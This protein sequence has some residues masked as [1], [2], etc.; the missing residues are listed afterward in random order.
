MRV[1]E[2]LLIPGPVSVSNEVLTALG[3]PVPPH[4]GE[5]WVELYS[6]LTAAVAGIF[7][8]A[9]DVILLFGPGTAAVET[10]L[11]S[12]LAPGDEV[13]VGVN[14]VFGERLA[15]VARALGLRV[16]EVTPP[17]FEPVRVEDLERALDEH[18]E[19]RAFAVVHH[20]TGLGLLNPVHELCPAAHGRGLLTLVD[21]FASF[22]GV[23]IRMDE[24]GIDL[25]AGTGN[26]CLG[27]P[28]GVAPVAIGPKGWAAVND[29]RPKAAG[30]YLNLATWHRYGEM[31][32]GWHPTPTT[33]P[34][35]V[36]VA[37]KAALDEVLD[38]GL[39]AHQARI[40][41]A[42]ARVR[43]G[44]GE[45]GF[46]MVIPGP[47]AAPMT[48]AVW[49]LPGMDVTAYMTWM[50]RERGLRL[51]GGLGAAMKGRSFRV[52]HMGRAA[53]PAVVDAYLRGT[54]EYLAQG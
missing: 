54:A 44:L 14:G 21:A 26:K 50:Q 2:T 35:N 29:G 4:Y 18:P 31:W 22:G 12:S 51:G 27:A 30:W 9:G 32:A 24:W 10:C 28:V 43:E 8:T 25:C 5:E 45:L 47:A 16:H 7:G 23:P 40:A 19:A 13:L 36:V 42:A 17:E 1:P 52:G 38:R 46:D 6:G 15:E 3:Q 41:A 49:G 33:M 20:E 37:L 39:E 11:G 34:S 53:E 48:T